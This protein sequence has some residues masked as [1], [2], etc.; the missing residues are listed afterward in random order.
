MLEMAWSLKPDCKLLVRLLGPVPS[1]DR[2]LL[3]SF[4]IF[5]SILLKSVAC[6]HVALMFSLPPSLPPSFPPPPSLYS[7]VAV[8]LGDLSA[9]AIYL[10]MSTGHRPDI[11]ATALLAMFALERSLGVCEAWVALQHAVTV[12]RSRILAI[13]Q[14]GTP[15]KQSKRK[16]GRSRSFRSGDLGSGHKGFIQ[17]AQFP[18]P[19]SCRCCRS[20]DVSG[21]SDFWRERTL[22]QWRPTLWA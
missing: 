17:N 2:F 20:L 15:M 8:F 4:K 22:T 9:N 10:S 7:D 18:K 16:F 12:T 19:Q 6:C 14:R 5:Q 13:R 21:R 3:R 1:H 11:F